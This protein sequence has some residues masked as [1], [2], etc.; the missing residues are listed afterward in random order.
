[1]QSRCVV[2]QPLDLGRCQASV[3]IEVEEIP[4]ICQVFKQERR[5]CHIG[6]EQPR[7][8]IRDALDPIYAPVEALLV[9]TAVPGRLDV[10]VLLYPRTRLLQDQAALTRR[11]PQREV[12]VALPCARRTDEL[13]SLQKPAEPFEQGANAGEIPQLEPWELRVRLFVFGTAGQ[14]VQHTGWGP[15]G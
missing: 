10:V 9:H 15:L 3:D 7:H 6:A 13:L 8:P 5:G 14:E 4:G 11:E 1:M 2:G 12:H